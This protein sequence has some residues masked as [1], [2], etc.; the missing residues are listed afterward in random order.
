[1]MFTINPGG[2]RAI[3]IWFIDEEQTIAAIE[4]RQQGIEQF[5]M[6]FN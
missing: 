3:A 4:S 1:M 6:R 5:V 2:C